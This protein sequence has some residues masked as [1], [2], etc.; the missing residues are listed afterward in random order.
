LYKYIIKT[1]IYKLFTS[2]GQLIP[3]YPLDREIRTM[4]LFRH[5]HPLRTEVDYSVEGT[6]YHR[7]SRKRRK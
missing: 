1:V 5:V 2:L 7:S 3:T 4:A 6:H